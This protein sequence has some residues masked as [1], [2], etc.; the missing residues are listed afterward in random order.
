MGKPLSLGLR[1]RLVGAVSGGMSRRSAAERFG[2]FAASAVRWMA[3]VNTTGSVEAKP[4]GGDTRSQRI[5]AFSAVILAAVAARKDISLV[6]LSELLRIEHGV[7]DLLPDR[8]AA[9][10]TAWLAARP[11]IGV[12][13]RDRGACYIQ[14][15]SVGRPNATQVADGWHLMENASAAFLTAVQHS[16]QGARA[17]VGSDVVD[18]AALTCAELR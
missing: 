6:E 12:I 16:M 10:V 11:S 18:P 8:E 17:A 15:A 14:A 2:V 9:T 3:A 1:S 13:A 7:I 5:E 4:Q